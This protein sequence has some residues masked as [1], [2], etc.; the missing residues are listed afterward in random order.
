MTTSEFK[1]TKCGEIFATLKTKG[2]QPD[3]RGCIY[4]VAE[5]LIRENEDFELMVSYEEY[6]KFTET[7]FPSRDKV[8]RMMIQ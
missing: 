3:E 1:E 6:D 2:Y 4:I 8:V 5:D 7:S